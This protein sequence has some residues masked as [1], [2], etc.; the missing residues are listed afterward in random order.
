MISTYL[1]PW[2]A[3]LLLAALTCC[4][5]SCSLG[6]SVR[7]NVLLKRGILVCMNAVISRVKRRRARVNSPRSSI[8]PGA[9]DHLRD[10]A[11]WLELGVGRGRLAAE[12][13]QGD[14]AHLSAAPSPFSRSLSPKLTRGAAIVD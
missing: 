10:L 4:L 7:R 6:I 1:P 14:G 5:H 11:L 2:L 13:Q 8:L 3:L 12:Q 9:C